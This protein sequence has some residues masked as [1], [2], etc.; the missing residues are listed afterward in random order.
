MLNPPLLNML[1]ELRKKKVYW[2]ILAVFGMLLA[3]GAF[4]DRFVASLTRKG[5][6]EGFMGL[7]V[8]LGVFVTLSGLSILS[9]NAALLALGAFAASGTPMIVGSIVRYVQ[10]REA[11]R[12]SMLAEI[13]K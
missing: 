2:R 9:I 4:Y 13:E 10:R 5:Y 1:L 12:K 7:I 8:A 6:A 3:F 11:A